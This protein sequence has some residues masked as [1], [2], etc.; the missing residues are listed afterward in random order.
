MRLDG[1]SQS[2]NV[3]SSESAS[4][5]ETFS[6][7]SNRNGAVP[8]QTASG[9][10]PTNTAPNSG[11]GGGSCLSSGGIAVVVSA[12][13][14]VLGLIFT[15]CFKIYKLKK[16]QAKEAQQDARGAYPSYKW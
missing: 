6:V 4:K 2:R 10:L 16:K 13:C 12:S 14:A 3:P 9:P 15:V 8:S 11:S 1:V 5:S 7:Y